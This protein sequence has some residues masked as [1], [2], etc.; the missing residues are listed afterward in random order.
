MGCR[1]NTTGQST[2]DCDTSGCKI[3]TQFTRQY[4]SSSR[5]LSRPHHR[6]G[7]SI[8]VGEGTSDIQQG[9]RVRNHFQPSGIGLIHDTE[10][11]A[12]MPLDR[13]AL[14]IDTPTGRWIGALVN[15]SGQLAAAATVH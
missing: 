6:E 12:V 14:A 1:I 3:V 7:H 10:Y 5:G 11:L 2:D 13:C 9:R 4:S 8:L 15:G